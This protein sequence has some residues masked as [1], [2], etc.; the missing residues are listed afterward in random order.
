MSPS[1][2]TSFRV[3]RD[4]DLAFDAL[5]D[6]IRRQILAVLSET[7]SCSA[8]ELAE[9]ITTVGRT[10]VSTH[11]RVLRTAGLVQERREGRYRYYSIE[12]GGAAADVIALLRT[13]FRSSLDD[14]R[15]AAEDSAARPVRDAAG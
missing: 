3:G 6:P 15:S 4:P 7:E 12:P 5:A 11:L 9:Q 8:G 1:D 13:L 2:D 14:A 10:A